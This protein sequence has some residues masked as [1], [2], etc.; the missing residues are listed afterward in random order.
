MINGTVGI[1]LVNQTKFK[2]QHSRRKDGKAGRS[3]WATYVHTRLYTGVIVT[4]ARD[5]NPFKDEYR[6]AISR[7]VTPY[8]VHM[9]FRD[10]IAEAV[11][12]PENKD[13]PHGYVERAIS[14]MEAAPPTCP[15]GCCHQY[16]SR[17]SSDGEPYFF[18]WYNRDISWHI[19]R[20][21]TICPSSNTILYPTGRQV[22]YRSEREWGVVGEFGGWH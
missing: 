16:L 9:V 22:Q 13:D 8:N 11:M 5:G 14:L 1:R 10:A 7:R 3:S 15:A 17:L 6:I 4:Q 2:W 19:I 12:F 21:P 20:I 18:G